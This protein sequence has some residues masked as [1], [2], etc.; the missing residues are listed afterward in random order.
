MELLRSYCYI[1]YWIGKPDEMFICSC[2]GD[3]GY[4]V[5]SDIGYLAEP[6]EGTGCIVRRRHLTS[7]E[8]IEC[9]M[10]GSH[11][12]SRAKEIM[13]GVAERISQEVLDG[14]CSQYMWNRFRKECRR[15]IA[16][17]NED[18]LLKLEFL[19]G[20]IANIVASYARVV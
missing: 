12:A 1:C 20:V 10:C 5:D 6:A 3:D 17:R 8:G 14:G 16:K 15:V 11:V 4:A 19:P 9:L 13:D 7:I 2:L 18:I